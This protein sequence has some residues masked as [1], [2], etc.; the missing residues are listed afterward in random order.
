VEYT[1]AK[2]SYDSTAAT[3]NAADLKNAQ[4][5]RDKAK[6]EVEQAQLN[7]DKARIVALLTVSSRRSA[8]T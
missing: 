1:S 6:L 5:S 2:A 3:I 7:L 4:V 8:L